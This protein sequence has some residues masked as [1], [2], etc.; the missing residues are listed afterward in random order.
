M[1]PRTK[2]VFSLAR[3]FRIVNAA[4]QQP[5]RRGK[6]RA[7]ARYEPLFPNHGRA[8]NALP[9]QI[10]G[11]FNAVSDLDKRDAAIHPKF[12]SV[13]RHCPYDRTG[14]CP[15]AGNRKSE[16]F[17]FRHAANGEVAVE[18]NRGGINL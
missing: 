15:L 9:L 18:L 10:D 14:T 11:Y 12:L 16:F 4:S 7:G 3:F 5:G 8:T 6:E 13:E 1:M 2:T 17:W